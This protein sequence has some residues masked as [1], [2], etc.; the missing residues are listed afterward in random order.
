M[1]KCSVC[2]D[3]FEE[4][5]PDLIASGEEFLD[6][7]AE[8]AKTSP[9]AAQAYQLMRAANP[10]IHSLDARWRLIEARKSGND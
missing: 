7:I 9:H 8:A 5:E 6:L 10:A 2:L 1:P 3:Y 4:R